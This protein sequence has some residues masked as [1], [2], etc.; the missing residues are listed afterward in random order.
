MTRNKE[1]LEQVRGIVKDADEKDI[2]FVGP[3]PWYQRALSNFKF[4]FSVGLAAGIVSGLAAFVAVT[5]NAP[6]IQVENQVI[7]SSNIEQVVNKSNVLESKIQTLEN[8]INPVV[9]K[10]FDNSLDSFRKDNPNLDF[11]NIKNTRDV[12]KQF[13][14]NNNF[15]AL[16]AEME[17]FLGHLHKDPA[18][19]LNIGFGY[20]IT[21][22]VQA[23]K[24]DVIKDLQS[25]G[26]DNYKITKVIE[27]SQKPQSQ[28]TKKIKEFNKEFDLANNQLVTLEQGVVLL[29]RT[30]NQYR[31]EAKQVFP[32]SF[33]KMGKHQQ[34]VLTY[35]AYKAGA[36]ALSKY[37]NAI[38]AASVAYANN[39]VP[40]SNQLKSIAKELTFYYAKDG[41]EMVLDERAA[42]I[43][44][45]FV[46]QDYL[47]VQIG[48]YDSLKQSP[49]KL[50]QEKLDFSHM[51]LKLDTVKKNPVPDLRAMLDKMRS[52]EGSESKI[53]YG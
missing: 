12:S 25:I 1:L 40:N 17:G 19:G 34:E 45:T 48:K 50:M 3:K 18:V 23:S 10:T 4:G 20:N 16:A 46:S 35:A 9:K 53:K 49:K 29:K 42:L 22:R 14:G 6:I 33:E 2:K 8:E 5:A 21:K 26:I 28:L 39:K 32:N 52:N 44:H 41:K 7:Y 24:E 43:A 31:T 27:L 13:L 51:D 47:G 37:K 11:A 15:I 36:D 30:Q 38:K